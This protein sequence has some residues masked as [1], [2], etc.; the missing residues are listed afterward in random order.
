MCI[1]DSAEDMRF[2]RG[3]AEKV[4]TVE[5]ELGSVNQLVDAKI[6]R[7]FSTTAR[8]AMRRPA[9]PDAGTQEINLSLIHI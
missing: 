3:I 8:E 4:S 6:Q 2:L 9:T 7:R 1:R 5:Q